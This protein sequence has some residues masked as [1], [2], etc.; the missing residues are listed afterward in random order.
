MSKKVIHLAFVL[1]AMLCGLSLHAAEVIDRIVATVNGQVILQSDVDEAISYQAFADG[2]PLNLVSAADRK[3]ALDRLID[4]ELIRQE[5]HAS[6][7]QPVPGAE[8]EARIADIRKLHPEATDD[9]SWTSA[10]HRY[11]LSAGELR[12]KVAADLNSWKAVEARLRPDV[13]INSGS[14]ERYYHENLLPALHKTG[15]PAPALVEV[16][17]KIKEI[18]TQQQ[19]NN[20]L[21]IWLKSLRNESRIEIAYVAGVASQGGSY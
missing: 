18:L 16:A 13:A 3:A 19:I 8:V 12:E 11:G 1:L 4:Q 15:A 10:L 6:D 2:R 5:V 14:V 20:L 21:A 7:F 17:P 9:A